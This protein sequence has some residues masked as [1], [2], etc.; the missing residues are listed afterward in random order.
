MA[1]SSSTIQRLTQELLNIN[2]K[3]SISFLPL[4]LLASFIFLLALIYSPNPSSYRVFP[5]RSNGTKC[6]LFDG[7]WVRD[8]ERTPYY[9]QGSCSTIPESKNCEKYG[10]EQGFVHWRWKPKGCDLPRFDAKRF[11]KIVEGKRM[12]FVGDSVSRNQMESLLCL[13]SQVETPIDIQEKDPEDRFRT[14]YFRSH[15]FTLL[16]LWTKFLISG[17]ELLENGTGTGVFD[18]HL[19][20]LDTSW[21]QKLPWLNYVVISTGHWYFRKNYLYENN[22]LIGCIYCSE[23]NL[24]NFEPAYAI[25]KSYRTTLQYINECKNC[26]GIVSILRTFSPAHFEN[27]DWNG[28]GICNRTEPLG[29]GEVSFGGTEWEVRNAQAEEVKREEGKGFRI[30]DVT[31][32]MTMRADAHPGI[33]WNNQWMKGYSDCVHWCL[34]GPVDVWNELMLEVLKEDDT[35]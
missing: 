10:K 7:E 9:T 31:K 27:G 16:T 24:T 29:N 4:F 6:D 18:L 33:H 8:F 14:W 23:S 21:P 22:N 3:S 2:I 11:L 5:Q 1:K 32:A 34:P 19:D 26:D 13:L 25:K 15:D 35:A 20:K 17:T 12:A 30:L 28:G